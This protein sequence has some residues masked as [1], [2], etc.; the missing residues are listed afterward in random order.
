MSSTCTV[1]TKNSISIGLPNYYNAQIIGENSFV[2]TVHHFEHYL[3]HIYVAVSNTSSTTCKS[4]YVVACCALYLFT[5]L[6]GL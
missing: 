5:F 6:F 2:I 3:N 4:T 1:G